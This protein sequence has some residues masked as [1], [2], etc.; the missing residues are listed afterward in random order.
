MGENQ[1]IKIFDIKWQLGPINEVG[2]NGCQIE[3][4]LPTFIDRLQSFQDGDFACRE[5]AIA[6]TKLEEALLWLHSRTDRRTKVGVE[7]TSNFC[8]GDKG[9]NGVDTTKEAK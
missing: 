1:G 8:K 2:V 5:N 7:G 9:F 3:D 6:C 4:I